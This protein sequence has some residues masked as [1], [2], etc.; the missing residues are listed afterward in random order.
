MR[1]AIALITLAA[2]VTAGSAV[3]VAQSKGRP[4]TTPAAQGP[5]PT[6]THGPKTTAAKGPKTT[7]TSRGPK[8]T[9]AHAPQAAARRDGAAKPAKPSTTTTANT[10]STATNLPR[11]PRLVE[12]LRILLNLPP[13]TDM[14]AVAAG[15]RNQGQFVAAV[16]VSNNLGITFSELKT[17]MVTDGLSLGQ[18]IQKLRPGVNAEN[19]VRRATSQSQQ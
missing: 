15:F 6:T 8:T 16:H 4:R 13:G 14:N 11:N 3:A 1:Y 17:L 9:T 7:T 2:F 5:K 10:P 18:A 19:E 12:R